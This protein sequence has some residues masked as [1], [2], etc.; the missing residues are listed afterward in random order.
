MVDKSRDEVEE[1]GGAGGERKVVAGC[2]RGEEARRS[3]SLRTRMVP[4]EH[5]RSG[6]AQAFADSTPDRRA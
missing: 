3:N 4:N 1:E 2:Y 5:N 6:I